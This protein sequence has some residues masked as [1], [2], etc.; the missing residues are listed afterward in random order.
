MRPFLFLSFALLTFSAGCT[1]DTT[2]I[3]EFVTVDA[4]VIALKGARVIDGTGAPGRPGQTIIIRDGCISEVGDAQTIRPPSDARVIDLSGRTILPGY[5]MAHEHL[6]FT[7]DGKGA[8]SMRSS[9]PRL[10]LA[11][12]ATTIRTAGSAGLSADVEVKRAIDQREVPGPHL[13]VTSPYLDGFLFLWPFQTHFS[14]GRLLATRWADRGATSFKVYEHITRDELT[15]VIEVA[16]ERHLK[17]TGHLCAV[18]FSEAID[19]GIDS[20]EHG[21]W[22]A[23]DFVKDKQPDVC[24]TPDVA[25]GA[26][27]SAEQWQIQTLIHRLVGR[28]VAVTSTLPVFETFLA[29]REPA[30]PEAVELFDAKTRRRYL[31]HRAELAAEPPTPVW[32]RLFQ[33]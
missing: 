20:I 29:S 31:D 17:V 14:R 33:K 1:H 18:T 13:D 7:P 4:A 26:V 2:P 22:T 30:P 11:G 27:L 5:V 12:G 10:Y 3:H 28:G 21:I 6:A 16:H 8:S 23:T 15:G 25:L 19:L 32:S 9:F 24:P